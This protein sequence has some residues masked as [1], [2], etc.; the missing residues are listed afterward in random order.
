MGEAKAK[1]LLAQG[2]HPSVE[3]LRQDQRQRWQQGDRVSAEAYM[4]AFPVLQSDAQGVLDLVL[5]E[6]DLRAE[7]G[8]TPQLDE[9]LARF[10]QFSDQLRRHFDLRVHPS[11]DTFPQSFQLKATHLSEV[12]AEPDFQSLRP[13]PSTS[14]PTLPGYEILGVLGRGGMGIVYKAR[15]LRL[16]RLV[17]LKMILS[18]AHAGSEALARFRV[19]AEAAA[20]LQHPNIVQI[21]EVGEHEGMAYCTLEFV[22]GTTLDKKIA[23]QPQP[24]RQA[25]ALVEVLARAMQ[26]AHQHQIIHRDLKPAN[27]LVTTEGVPKITD[28]GLAKRLEEEGL[29]VS[30]AIMGTPRYM[31]PEQA[32]GR[33]KEIGPASDGHALGVILYE[34]LTGRPPFEGGSLMETLEQVRTREAVSPRRWQPQIPRDL[35]TICLK[36]LEKEIP[37]RYASALALAD[38]LHRFLEDQPILARPARLPTR[39]AKWVRR[40]P[41]VATLAGLL[42]LTTSLGMPMGAWL[43]HTR[44][45]AERGKAAAE[46]EIAKQEQAQRANQRTESKS[47]AVVT[48]GRGVLEGVGLVLSAEQARR[49]QVSYQFT[50]RGGRLEEVR[51]LNGHGHLTNLH[52][53]GLFLDDLFDSSSRGHREC[54]YVT[55]RDAQ[56][57]VIKEIGYDRAGRVYEFQYDAEKNIGHYVNADGFPLARAGTGAAYVRFVWS[58]N[59]LQKEIRYLDKDGKPRAGRDGTYGMRLEY[60][61]HNLPLAVTLLDAQGQPTENQHGFAKLTLAYDDQAQLIAKAFVGLDGRPQPHRDGYGKIQ[62]AYDSA[63]NHIETVCLGLDGRPCLQREGF[64]RKTMLYDDSGNCVETAFWGLDGQPTLL[65]EGYAKFLSRYDDRGLEIERTFLG[66][67]GQPVRHVYGYAK[68]AW[69]RDE[70]GNPIAE[71]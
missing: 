69:Q 14:W 60:N 8:E 11:V 47:Y 40:R 21:Y 33:I 19:E 42:A 46:Q 4:A 5:H 9:Y 38:D 32:W 62:F 2:S 7:Q 51:V 68:L 61:E 27:V 70:H 12:S 41:L 23:G 25:A 53:V 31:A 65:A 24:A 48:N 52:P 35:E 17:A 36:C 15:H 37:R 30:D 64:A 43:W 50:T 10:P 18:G 28:F 57:R 16:K 45:E 63:G 26:V 13:A 3:E 1:R 6:V 67:D 54:R 39:L 29:T 58:E 59:N 22:D 44:Q 20:R 71:T 34:L 49:R 66:L 55:Q 56:G